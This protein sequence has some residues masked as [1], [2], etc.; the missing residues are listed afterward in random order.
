M[1]TT[2]VLM[3]RYGNNAFMICILN[4]LITII[5][6][7]DEMCQYSWKSHSFIFSY[8]LYFNRSQSMLIIFILSLLGLQNIFFLRFWKISI[9]SFLSLHKAFKGFKCLL[10]PFSEKKMYV[11]G[12][13]RTQNGLFL[14]VL[15]H[16]KKNN[17]SGRL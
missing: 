11:W 3:W 15:S 13:R 4:I 1:R 9:Q 16:P 6:A 12:I 2:C 17:K 10:Y 14:L 5:R 8:C 7:L